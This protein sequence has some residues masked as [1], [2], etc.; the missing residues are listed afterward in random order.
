MLEPSLAGAEPGSHWQLERV[1]Y[2][3]VD[4]EDSRP[5][6]P[7]LN[8]IVTLRDSWSAGPRPPAAAPARRRR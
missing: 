3:V 7:V 6:A 5:G 8:R 4:A 1:G 2:F